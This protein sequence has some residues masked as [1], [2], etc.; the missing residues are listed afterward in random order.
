[1]LRYRPLVSLVLLLVWGLSLI[2]VYVVPAATPR[3][4]LMTGFRRAFLLTQDYQ[5]TIFTLLFGLF[6][7]GVALFGFVALSMKHV[8]RGIVL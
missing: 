7:V 3:W 6:F 2:H 8:T 5:P 1:M 4:A